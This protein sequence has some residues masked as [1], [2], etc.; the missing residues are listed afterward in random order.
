MFMIGLV[1]SKDQNHWPLRY[2]RSTER[3]RLC[4]STHENQFCHETTTGIT[5]PTLIQASIWD[6]LLLILNKSWESDALDNAHL[7]TLTQRNYAVSNGSRN[8]TEITDRAFTQAATRVNHLNHIN[9]GVI[10]SELIWWLITIRVHNVIR[11]TINCSLRTIQNTP[12][13][14]FGPDTLGV[15]TAVTERWFGEQP[16]TNRA[17]FIPDSFLEWTRRIRTET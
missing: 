8:Q 2:Y 15:T 5:G 12:L 9:L 13:T 7:I 3:S 6:I 4:P 17:I 11:V 14:T 16:W 1:P 10:T